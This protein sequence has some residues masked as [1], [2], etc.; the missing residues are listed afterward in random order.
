MDKNIIKRFIKLAW[1]W[2]FIEGALTCSGGFGSVFQRVDNGSCSFT[3]NDTC[4]YTIEPPWKPFGKVLDKPHC[5][6]A[7]SSREG[8]VASITSQVLP[9]GEYCVT[10]SYIILEGDNAT[11]SVHRSDVNSTEE[12]VTVTGN[13]TNEWKTLENNVFVQAKSF[14]LRFTGHFDKEGT[15]ALA[16]ITVFK[17]FNTIWVENDDSPIPSDQPIFNVTTKPTIPTTSIQPSTVV[18]K[19]CG[20][21]LTIANG[22]VTTRGSKYL[23]QATYYCNEGYFLIGE[24]NTTCLENAT[25]GSNNVSCEPM[26]CGTIIS[27]DH[28]HVIY[29]NSTYLSSAVLVCDDGYVLNGNNTTSCLSNGSWSTIN[30]DCY[31]IEIK[32][33]PK[34]E[35]ESYGN[36]SWDKTDPGQIVSCK[37]PK[38][39]EGHISRKCDRNGKWL[40]PESNCVRPEIQAIANKHR[41]S[42]LV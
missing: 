17:A 16:D 32:N 23:D 14:Q 11:L 13:Y 25:W 29:G 27:N 34:C 19:E 38:N 30:A 35:Q 20:T 12:L 9:A 22:G 8:E 1:L 42:A 40:L 39:F 28:G 24:E 5:V 31:L 6:I 41:R 21:N 15:V 36:C 33:I 4:G 18:S 3:N 37:C 26:D 10:F 7:N 2:T